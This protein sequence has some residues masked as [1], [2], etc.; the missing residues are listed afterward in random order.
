MK[1]E[2][3][4]VIDGL[5]KYIDAEIYAKMNDLQEFMARVLIG[6]FIN[7]EADVK[8][9]LI[10][11]GFIRTFGIIDGDGMVD[12]TALAKDIKREIL[13]KQQ[14]SFDIPMFGKMT[15]KPADVDVIYRHITGE[16]LRNY[17]ND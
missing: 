4:K 6:R 10:N 5:S 11:N 9:S 2:F 17:E 15:F 14:I 7:N 8:Q 3:E 16:E 1:H 12:V 13:K